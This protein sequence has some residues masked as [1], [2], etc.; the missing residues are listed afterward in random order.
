M[1]FNIKNYLVNHGADSSNN[2]SLRNLYT[3]PTA[4]HKNLLI[5]IT[6]SRSKGRDKPPTN[7]NTLP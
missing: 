6:V 7:N 4:E 2:F 1:N 5:K 3:L